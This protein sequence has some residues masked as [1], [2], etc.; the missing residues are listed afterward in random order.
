MGVTL[1][2]PGRTQTLTAL[3]KVLPLMPNC[4]ATLSR[5]LPALGGNISTMLSSS[6]SVLI[7][8]SALPFRF[9]CLSLAAGFVGFWQAC[10]IPNKSHIFHKAA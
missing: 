3:S 2:S 8:A 5:V 10:H 7:P 9:Q 4:S 1:G 6:K